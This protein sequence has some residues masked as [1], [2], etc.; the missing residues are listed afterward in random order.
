MANHTII[1]E[2][3]SVSWA[4]SLV[5]SWAGLKRRFLR[6]LITM[7][8]VILAIA[9]LAYMAILHGRVDKWLSP[10]WAA[11]ASIMAFGTILM[12]YLGVNYVLAAG[13]HSYGF[14]QSKVATWLVIAAVAETAFV[15]AGAL[16][17]R[18]NRNRFGSAGP[19]PTPATVKEATP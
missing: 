13:L 14:G 19:G 6:S 12:T 16:A 3:M 15:V 18:R 1:P 7:T 4:T 11:A 2:Q 10:F 8:G 9:F 5:I 17:Y